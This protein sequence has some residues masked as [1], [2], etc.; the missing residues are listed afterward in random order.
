MLHRHFSH[1]FLNLVVQVRQFID[2]AILEQFSS[3]FIDG[4][5]PCPE[6]VIWNVVFSVIQ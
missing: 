6:F 5:L 2:I 3:N 1:D 4:F